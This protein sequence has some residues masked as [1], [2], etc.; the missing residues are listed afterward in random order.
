MAAVMTTKVD[1]IPVM[2]LRLFGARGD[3][4]LALAY[5]ALLLATP[6]HFIN[7]DKPLWLDENWTGAIVAPNSLG[8]VFRQ[9]LFDVNAPFY[10]LLEHFWTTVF[11]LS[12]VALRLPSALFAAAAAFV[13]IASRI[14]IDKDTKILWAALLALWIPGLD[15]AQEA[16]CYALLFFLATFN[17]VFFARLLVN[18]DTRSAVAWAAVSLLLI[19]THYHALLLVGMQGIIV[20]A[21]QRSKALA[22]WPA[23]IV[24]LPLLPWMAF[25]IGLISRFLDPQ[26]TWY[27]L[28]QFRDLDKVVEFLANSGFVA[29]FALLMLLVVLW[30]RA[31]AKAATVQ[32]DP[33]WLVFVASFVPALIII[34]AGFIR[35]SF[36]FRYLIPF[37]PGLLLGLALVA[38]DA[39]DTWKLAPFAMLVMFA[40]VTSTWLVKQI[41]ALDNPYSFEHAS[42]SLIETGT[43]RLIFFWDNPTAKAID[44]QQLAAVGGFFFKRAGAPVEV[45]AIKLQNGEDPND[46]LAKEAEQHDA[47]V[48]WLYD[49]GVGGTA[50]RAHAPTLETFDP[51][52][53]CQNFGNHRFGII[54]CRQKDRRRN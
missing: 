46:R 36:T 24:F 7:L 28:L 37:G 26:V 2:N 22:L 23:L 43:D 45:T 17:A 30:R 49:L 29:G 12:N 4:L 50:A 11:G 21:W 31:H 38:R 54:T 8:A 5:T 20:L 34:G 15:Y 35:P 6:L 14:P 9:I 25:R 27:W 51:A 42:Q 10:F 40:A 13:V 52:L 1:K 53:L 19:L 47:A 16:R 41:G 48:L 3:P 44:P 39:K 32:V 33:L 18:N